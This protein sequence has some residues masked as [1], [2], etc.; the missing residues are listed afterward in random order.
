MKRL[1]MMA[2]VALLVC[3]TTAWGHGE[4][5]VVNLEELFS[6]YKRPAV[7]EGQIR[8]RQ[9]EI[10]KEADRRREIIEQKAQA[11]QAFKPGTAEF[12]EGRQALRR[13]EIEF[14][15]WRTLAD[16]EI[17]KRH[18]DSFLAIYDDV[19]RGVAEVAKRRGLM[20]VLTYDTLA[21]EAQDSQR[22]RQ[23]ILLQ[24]VIF[25]KPE[26]DITEEVL[27]VI[28]DAFEAR[29][30]EAGAQGDA[31]SPDEK[32]RLTQVG[33]SEDS[34]RSSTNAAPLVPARSQ[35]R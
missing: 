7:L 29:Q 18:R 6:L 1:S 33:S 21:H 19:R 35:A 26:L 3:T 27:K 32:T 25:W 16:E 17:K 11:M 2:G 34:L 23:Q 20:V 9:E 30:K 24:K 10:I 13:E 14:Q 4:T 5:A 28:N 31:R 22:L 15:V 12:D 8:N